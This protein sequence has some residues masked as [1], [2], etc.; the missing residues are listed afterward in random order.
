MDDLY[1]PYMMVL[2]AENELGSINT[3]NSPVLNTGNY[4]EIGSYLTAFLVCRRVITKS[5]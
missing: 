5:V 4:L 2:P 3:V 1:A